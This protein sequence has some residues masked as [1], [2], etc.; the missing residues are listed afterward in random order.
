MFFHVCFLMS[1]FN[2]ISMGNP[3]NERLAPGF[4]G[5]CILDYGDWLDDSYFE[6]PDRIGM[7]YHWTRFLGLGGLS[8]T[9]ENFSWFCRETT[10]YVF[11]GFRIAVVFWCIFFHYSGG[12]SPHRIWWL[13]ASLVCPKIGYPKFPPTGELYVFLIWRMAIN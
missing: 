4:W 3:A 5:G 10:C 2:V 7:C 11:R 13:D 9:I 1:M 12:L 6:F 8:Y